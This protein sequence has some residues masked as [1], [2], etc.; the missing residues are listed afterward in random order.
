MQQILMRICGRSLGQA[1]CHSG[2]QTLS[3]FWLHAL[4]GPQ[5]SLPLVKKCRKNSKGTQ[6][7][8]V[9]RRECNQEATEDQCSVNSL[10]RRKHRHYVSPWSPSSIQGPETEVQGSPCF[11]CFIVEKHH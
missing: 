3:I 4:L 1:L 9:R 8:L 5:S 10:G 11:S 7:S 6:M 2:A